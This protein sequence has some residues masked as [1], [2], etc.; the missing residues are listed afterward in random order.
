[1]TACWSSRWRCCARWV[2]LAIEASLVAVSALSGTSGTK[3]GLGSFI[4][5]FSSAYTIHFTVKHSMIAVIERFTMQHKVRN[6][7][8]ALLAI[9]ASL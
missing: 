2:L 5:G 3:L 4:L 6:A 1:M 8:T 9:E 7:V